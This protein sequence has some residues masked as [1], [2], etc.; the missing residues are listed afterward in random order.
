MSPIIWVKYGT[1]FFQV[2]R[3]CAPDKA[4]TWYNDTKPVKKQK[5]E[6]KKERTKLKKKEKKRN[7][8]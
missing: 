4:F 2:F 5:Q 6:R 1:I 7:K 3:L 8:Q